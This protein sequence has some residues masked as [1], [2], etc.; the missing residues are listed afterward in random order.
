MN[1]RFLSD[2]RI[3][4]LFVA[5]VATFLPAVDLAR[6][7]E[8]TVLAD[9]TEH[10]QR[11]R[12][13]EA[14]EAFAETLK[15]DDDGTRS[16]AIIGLSRSLES[17][18]KYKEAITRLTEASKPSPAALAE[19][20]RLQYAIG[21]LE[22]SVASCEAALK[23]DVDQP[24]AHLILARLRTESGDL[25]KANDEF[26]WFVRYYNRKQPTDAETLLF[27]ADGAGEY[28]R[29]NSNSS[30]FN[31]IINT[32]CVDAL[33]DDSLSWQAHFA[34]GSLL[35]EKYNRAQAIPDLEKALEINPR[36]VAVIVALGGIA[37]ARYRRCANAR[38]TGAQSSGQL[39]AD[40]ATAG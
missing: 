12:Y 11:G 37:E 28:A 4:A 5:V 19:A 18:G 16:A 6:A 33:K 35:L 23:A 40:A 15:S 32:L 22:E 2:T 17:Q 39:C 26:R 38:R 25:K 14:A 29:W 21:R 34:S 30:I 7:D 36:A 1:V 9:A 8:A 13:E 31:F 20:A 3:V 27:I 24:L 10:L